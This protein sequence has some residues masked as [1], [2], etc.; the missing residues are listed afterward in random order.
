MVQAGSRITQF[1][2]ECDCTA[3]RASRQSVVES[4]GCANRKAPLIT[5]IDLRRRPA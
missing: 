4:S 2:S 3:D 5:L 1:G